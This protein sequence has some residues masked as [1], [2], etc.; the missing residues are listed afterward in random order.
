[1]AK[2]EIV[3][4]A[5]CWFCRNGH[6]TGIALRFVFC[7]V[8]IVFEPCLNQCLFMTEHMICSIT[9]SC[10]AFRGCSFSILCRR[11]ICCSFEDGCTCQNLLVILSQF[12]GLE[13]RQR[14]L[15]L[16]I[17]Q[18]THTFWDIEWFYANEYSL[19]FVWVIFFAPFSKKKK[20]CSGQTFVDI[21]TAFCLIFRLF[22][23]WNWKNWK[24][25]F[26]FFKHNLWTLNCC[27][28]MFHDLCL[29]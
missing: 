4:S 17:V 3:R 23:F 16:Q 21:K 9:S 12:C 24:N 26:K 7:L 1:M 25:P 5:G 2:N 18:F 6:F 20:I 8:A 28:R 14:S 29:I 27:V 10:A 15:Q 11:S 22:S 19:L 13:I